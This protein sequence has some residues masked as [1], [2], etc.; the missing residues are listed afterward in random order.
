MQESLNKLL[1]TTIREHWNYPALS[2]FNGKNLKYSDVAEIIFALH[3]MFRK[4]GLK[5]GD[6]VVICGK[7][8]ANWATAFLS[9]VGYGAVAIPL[10]YDFHKDTL[11]HLVKH[12]DAKMM[13][14]DEKLFGSIDGDSISNIKGAISLD[15]F[16]TIYRRRGFSLEFS[17]PVLG[18]K[19]RDKSA[20]KLSPEEF[21]L[22]K[23]APEDLCVINYTS[24]STGF[25]KGVMLPRRSLVS[26]LRFAVENISYLHPDDGIVSMLPLAHA[27]GLSIEFLFPFLKGCHIVFLGK[28]P[29]PTL[30]LKA[31]SCVR[32]KIIIAVPLI[33]EKIVRN[34]IY[35]EINKP[36]VKTLLKLPVVRNMVYGKIRNKLISA[37]GGKL[38]QL[39]IGGAPLNNDVEALLRK[40]EFPVTVGYGMT[41][42]GPLIAYAPWN[43]RPLGSCGRIVDGLEMKIC[44]EDPKNKAGE[45]LV[46]GVNVMTGYYKADEA[47]SSVFKDGWMKT[48][49]L[50]QVDENGY[51]Y[52]R[53]RNKTMILGASGQNIYPEEIES[54]LNNMPLVA[55]SL[56]VDRKGKLVA[57]I[58]PDYEEIKKK[59]LAPAKVN[60]QMERN[61]E[62]LNSAGAVYERVASFEI[63]PVEFDKTPKRSIK[64]FL[65]D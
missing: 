40:I 1:E 3:G 36:L 58:V 41:E 6:K 47:T 52:I 54:R 50:C 20:E 42:C 19:P 28:V 38:V 33:L 49:D 31:F 8:S 7:N 29:A 26:N 25:S 18:D 48:G 23:D 16:T 59:K 2:D 60:E 32:P 11:R 37:F 45:L 14:T 39:I 35:P 46:R 64:R 9:I 56:I 30:I 12:C 21:V 13:F 65:Y 4:S 10:L 61:M 62:M 17:V 22:R 43:E 55:E 34:K 5:P 15:D 24:G 57:L 53:G 44:S 51:I 63:M 27:F